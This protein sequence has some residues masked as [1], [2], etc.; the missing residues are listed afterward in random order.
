VNNP[1]VHAS[2]KAAAR[3]PARRLL[4][5]LKRINRL[6]LLTVVLPTLLASAYFGLIA[7]DVYVSESRF[8]VRTPGRETASPIGLMLQSA[9]FTPAQNDTYTVQDY[10]LSRD[11]LAA[12][13]GALGLKESFSSASVDFLN[14]FAFLD[15]NDSLEAL[16][17]YYQGM[18]EMELDPIS[19]IAILTTRA[20]TAGEAHAMNARLL[21]QAEALVNALNERGRQDMIRFASQ[22]VAAA[23]LQAEEAAVALASYRDAKGIMDPE[24]QS[25]IPLQQIGKLR[26]ELIA[27]K[28]QIAQLEE[29]AGDNPQLPVLRQRAALLAGEIEA[30]TMRVAGASGESL[31]GKASQYQRFLLERE[32]ADK[33]LAS[34]MSSLE[35][36]RNEAQRKQLYLERIAQPSLPD[37]AMEPRRLRAVLAVLVLGLVSWGVLTMLAAGIAEHR[38]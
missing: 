6:A 20:Y 23:K 21:D 22:E 15:G 30:E 2:L 5:R 18:V 11:A 19:S 35:R 8:V 28:S 3:K 36:A 34:A 12:L 38:D 16:Y 31:A 27:T 26:D 37:A 1:F 9:G 33:M 17:L 14:R 32:F 4:P 13:N 10:M 29:L 24:R 25:T 7:S